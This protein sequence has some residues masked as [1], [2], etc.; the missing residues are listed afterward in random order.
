M[1]DDY[2]EAGLA[3][4]SS[5]ADNVRSEA[6]AAEGSPSGSRAV[7]RTLTPLSQSSSV[8]PILSDT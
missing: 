5:P 3:K 7:L 8:K 4:N 1:V 2:R 6:G